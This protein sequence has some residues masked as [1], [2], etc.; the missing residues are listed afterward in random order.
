MEK[1]ETKDF[2]AKY[3]SEQTQCMVLEDKDKDFNHLIKIMDSSLIDDCPDMYYVDD[4]N[5]K[6][7]IFEHFEYDASKHSTK[8]SAERI[9]RNKDDRDFDNF[10]LNNLG[11][12][13]RGSVK[14]ED[15]VFYFLENVKKIFD[16]HYAKIKMYKQRTLSK[17]TVG[18]QYDFVV[19]FILEDA[20]IF[21]VSVIL[22]GQMFGVI[23]ILCR[24]FLEFLDDKKEVQN[25]ICATERS[26]N[27]RTMA[28]LSLKDLKE[29]KNLSVTILDKKIVEHNAQ[30]IGISLLIKPPDPEKD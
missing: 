19:T 27:Q 7:Y 6:I 18:K 29:A 3:L 15:S 10:N 13:Y 21:G 26:M 16:N 1:T 4:K 8:G 30:S 24:E 20:S 22:N 25:I 28:F 2:R 9:K 5:N 23:P 11:K 17:A 14:S 12:M